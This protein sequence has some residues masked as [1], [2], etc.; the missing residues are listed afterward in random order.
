MSTSQQALSAGDSTDMLHRG[1]SGTRTPIKHAIIIIGENRTFDHVFATYKPKH[2]QRISNLLSQGIVNEDGTPGPHFDRALQRTAVDSAADGYKINPGSKSPYAKLPAPLTGGPTNANFSDLATAKAV[3]AGLPDSYYQFLL[4]GGTGLPSKVVDTRISNVNNLPPGPFQLTPGVPYDAYAASPVHRFY[5][6]W[7]QLDCS[8]RDASFWNPSGCKND[9]FPWVE[10]SF[11]A[12][13]NG[14]PPPADLNDATT[15]EGSTAMGFY[16]VLQGDAPYLKFLADTYSMSDNYHQADQGG[17]GANHVAIGTGDAIW[18]SDGNGHATVPPTLNTENP[19]AQPGTNNWY[20]QD[21]Y[22]GGTYSDCEDTTQPGVAS[23]VNYLSSLPRRVNPNCEKG[24]YYLLNNYAP[25]YFADGTVNTD[26]FAIPPSTL[27]TIGDELGE[28]NISWAYFG[29]QYN[30]YQADPHFA[31]PANVYCDI[32]NPFQYATSIMTNAA[33]RQEHLK[34][35]LDF[36]QDIQNGIL[37]AV[38]FVKPSGIVD[39]HPASSKLDLFEG[40]TKYIVDL[41]QSQPDLWKDTAI[42]VTFDEGGGYY[43]SGYVQ[44]VDYFGDGTRVPLLVVSPYSKGGRISHEYGDH[45]SLLKFIEFN[46]RLAPVTKR[47]R[48]NLPN[49]ITSEL[50]P[51]APV[52]SPAIGDLL[53]LFDFEGRE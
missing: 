22:S 34:D 20:T 33:S 5:Q 28:K 31:N 49:P 48:D 6:M 23:V 8:A 37:P 10:V 43:D 42:F 44:P 15:G 14:A 1:Q 19:N 26:Q 36:Y 47:S 32:C 4:T 21:G 13:S 51:Y 27:R 9:L 52:N 46:W 25:G 2:H 7:Q 50:N 41:V 30:R 16:N 38:S 24:H 40:F 12:G 11:G 53:S 17:T 45:V 35:T 29:D 39:G 3:Q 18:F